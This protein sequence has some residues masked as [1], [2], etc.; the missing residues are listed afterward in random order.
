MKKAGGLVKRKVLPSRALVAAREAIARA[1]DRFDEAELTPLVSENFFLDVAPAKRK[2]DI[3]K[4]R[5]ARGA[6]HLEGDIDAENALRGAWTMACERGSLR[7]RATLA[8]TLPPRK[9]GS[10]RLDGIELQPA[11]WAESRCAR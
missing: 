11:E 1:V 4:L 9:D 6:C 5:T 8:P 7:V 2:E 3:A 10:E